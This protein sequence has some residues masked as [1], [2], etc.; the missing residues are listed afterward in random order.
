[1]SGQIAMLVLGFWVLLRRQTPL[2]EGEPKRRDF[3]RT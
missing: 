3:A 1:M 2:G